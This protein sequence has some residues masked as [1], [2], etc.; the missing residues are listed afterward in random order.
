MP[1]VITAV[2]LALMGC[3]SVVV[4]YHGAALPHLTPSAT[5]QPAA[6]EISLPGYPHALGACWRATGALCQGIACTPYIGKMPE[7]AKGQGLVCKH[8][9][10]DEKKEIWVYMFQK[11]GCRC[12]VLQGPSLWKDT[13]RPTA[14][15]TDE[16]AQSRD[17]LPLLEGVSTSCITSPVGSSRGLPFPPWL[18]RP[19]RG[20]IEQ[21]A[22]VDKLFCRARLV[23]FACMHVTP[24]YRAGSDLTAY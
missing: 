21:G 15:P 5:L 3:V 4:F 10:Y 11:Y 12:V 23:C 18:L 20:G 17:P 8:R 24:P 7:L 14:T 13:P 2:A 19:N 9:R 22:S 1:A 6:T 16:E